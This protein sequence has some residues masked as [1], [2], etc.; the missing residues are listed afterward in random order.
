MNE[1]QNPKLLQ[2]WTQ[3]LDAYLISIKSKRRSSDFKGSE[4]A[5]A[6][7]ERQKPAD[8]VLYGPRSCFVEVDRE[9]ETESTQQEIALYRRIREIE[10]RLEANERKRRWFERRF[11]LVFVLA[12][13]IWMWIAQ[14]QFIRYDSTLSEVDTRSV[15]TRKGSLEREQQLISKMT[16]LEKRVKELENR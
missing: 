2:D 1:N 7:M 4:L 3:E 8:F 15:N 11:S 6:A 10:R 9:P 13:M 16:N 12:G 14:G 5:V